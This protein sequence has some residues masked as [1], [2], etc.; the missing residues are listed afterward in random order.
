[1]KDRTVLFLF[2]L[3]YRKKKSVRYAMIHVIAGLSD[4]IFPNDRVFLKY[5]ELTVNTEQYYSVP[6]NKV[7]NFMK[8]KYHYPC[9]FLILRVET[10]RLENGSNRRN[11][12]ACSYGK[13]R[14]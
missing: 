9:I 1:M 4:V 6:Y 13:G 14:W 2:H 8:N 10:A 3:S 7:S 11:L 5:F 12:G